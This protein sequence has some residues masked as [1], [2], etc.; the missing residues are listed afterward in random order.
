MGRSCDGGDEEG[1][2]DYQKY[3]EEDG[4]RVDSE[5][6]GEIAIAAAVTKEG[7]ENE[8]AVMK[9]G[10]EIPVVET[11]TEEDEAI[12]GMLNEEDEAIAGVLNEYLGKELFSDTE[13]GDEEEEELPHYLCIN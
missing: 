5:G 6:G 9:E 4:V 3:M 11:M 1:G 13:G 7:D 10:G 12:A 8:A 2:A